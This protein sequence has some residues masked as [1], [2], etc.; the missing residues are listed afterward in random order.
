MNIFYNKNY[1]CLTVVINVYYL[2]FNNDKTYTFTIDTYSIR[3]SKHK[4]ANYTNYKHTRMIYA[5]YETESCKTIIRV[6]NI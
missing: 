5:E 3:I 2:L 1:T 6:H 4:Q